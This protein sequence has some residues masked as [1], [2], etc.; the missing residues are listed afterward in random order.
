MEEME[1]AIPRATVGRLPRYLR[2][3]EETDRSTISSSEIATAAGVESAQVRRDLSYLG[4]I[5]TRG[6]GYDVSR[7]RAQISL[8]LG[9]AG[10]VRVAIIGAGNLGQA[11]AGYAGFGAAGFEVVGL[12]DK[13][14][15]KV[16]R[17]VHGQPVHPIDRLEADAGAGLFEIAIIATPAEVAAG[18]VVKLS[19]AG[20][21]SILNFA[22]ATVKAPS[23]VEVRT[24]DLST[25]L[26]ILSFYRR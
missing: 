10:P 24:V 1:R 5:G 7:L 11:L 2:C 16:G 26:Q 21:R 25:E 22:P 20:V 3:L 18:I 12:Y 19:N 15:R 8:L 14:L 6:V 9:L 23:G 4:S 17:T 13:D